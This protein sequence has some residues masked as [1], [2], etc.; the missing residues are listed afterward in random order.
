MALLDGIAHALLDNDQ[1]HFAGAAADLHDPDERWLVTLG[2]PLAA[3]NGDWLDSLPS[4]R[5]PATL[6]DGV[7]GMWDVRDRASF[8]ARAAWL[9]NEGQRTAYGAVWRSILAMDVVARSMHPLL[10][11]LIDGIAPQFLEFKLDPRDGTRAVVA[12]SGLSMK[13][14]VETRQAARG[15]LPRIQGMLAVDPASVTSLVAWDAVRLA[16]LARWAVSLGFIQRPEFAV[17][18]GGLATAVRQAYAGWPQVS[19]AYIAAGLIW[20][21]SDAREESLLRTNAMLL[22]DPRSPYRTVPFR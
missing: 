12:E 6:A 10:R 13:D 3:F 20:N 16:S 22:A 4:R 15:W 9:R 11:G 14:V 17:V 8:E 2:A 19:A 7:A 21:H 18:A 5:D 1:L